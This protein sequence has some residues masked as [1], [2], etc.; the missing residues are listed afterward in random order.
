MSG[1]RLFVCVDSSA[2][3]LAAARLALVMAQEHGGT[4]RAVSVVENERM[5]RGARAMLDRIGALAAERG[6]PIET[7]MRAGEPLGELMKDARRWGPDFILIGRTG[8]AGPGS[9]MLGSLAMHV[10][11]FAVGPVVVVPAAPDG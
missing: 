8:R 10:I 4:L 11:E 5:E 3:A 7:E 2:G 1:F 9:P 6:I